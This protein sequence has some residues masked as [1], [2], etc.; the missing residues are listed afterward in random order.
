MDVGPVHGFASVDDIRPG[1]FKTRRIAG[2]FAP[3]KIA[4]S[5]HY[6][7]IVLQGDLTVAVASDF[8]ELTVPFSHGTFQFLSAF[9]LSFYLPPNQVLYAASSVAGAQIT[10]NVAES[11]FDCCEYL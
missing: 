11:I 3:I 8:G 4:E 1:I 6:L 9:P 7:R 5:D 10:I 2:V